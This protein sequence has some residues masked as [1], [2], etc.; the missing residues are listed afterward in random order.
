[1][2]S[3][4]FGLRPEASPVTTVHVDD[5][6]ESLGPDDDLI[7]IGI[8]MPEGGI[9]VARNLDEITRLRDALSD[10]IDTPLP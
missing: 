6:R 8:T 10:V 5:S 2:K 7:E 3:R 4:R 1:M 9:G